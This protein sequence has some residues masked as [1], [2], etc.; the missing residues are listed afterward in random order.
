MDEQLDILNA[1][2]AECEIGELENC[3]V[4]CVLCP[5][6]QLREKVILL[7]MRKELRM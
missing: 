7:I 6:Y 2:C 4:V 5:V 1:E 3:S